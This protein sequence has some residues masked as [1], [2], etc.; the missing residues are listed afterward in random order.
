MDMGNSN[1]N[2]KKLALT[3]WRQFEDIDL[4]LHTRLTII[5]GANGAGKS[6]IIRIFSKHFGFDRPYL[7]SQS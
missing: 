1:T 2:F 6:S 4:D 7:N 5:T 3:G